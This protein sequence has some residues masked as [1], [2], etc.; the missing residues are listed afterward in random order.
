[1]TL[2]GTRA[3][4]DVCHPAS[5][6]GGCFV[7]EGAFQAR[8]GTQVSLTQAYAHEDLQCALWSLGEKRLPGAHLRDEM[9]QSSTIQ[10][11]SEPLYAL[12]RDQAAFPDR[13]EERF[14]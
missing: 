6:K 11:A 8:I 5:Q 4:C 3:E 2:G 13:S 12:L 7:V 10:R 14:L 9:M 1:M